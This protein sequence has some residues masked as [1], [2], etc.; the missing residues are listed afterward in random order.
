MLED[1]EPQNSQGDF[2]DAL[3]VGLSLFIEKFGDKPIQKRI[4]LVTDGGSPINYNSVDSITDALTER[5]AKLNVIGVGFS[6]AL[7]K[8]NMS[9]TQIE[10]EKQIRKIVQNV[11]GVLFPVANAIQMMSVLKSGQP[12]KTPVFKGCLE[13]SPLLK[14]PVHSF[15]K[16][17]KAGEPKKTRISLLSQDPDSNK[18]VKTQCEYFSFDNIDV[19]IPKTQRSK[20]YKYGNTIVSFSSQDEKVLKFSSA[21]GMKLIG[22][23]PMEKVP[24]YHFMGNVEIVA[25][26][27]HDKNAQSAISALAHAM[28]ETEHCAII[29]YSKGKNAPFIAALY[30]R[31]KQEMDS[32]YCV[33]L[34]FS[35]DIRDYPFQPLSD[36]EITEEQLQV[37][38]DVINALDLTK[39]TNDEGELEEPFKPKNIHNPSLQHLYQVLFHKALHPD[40]DIPPILPVIDESVSPDEELFRKNQQ[41]LT[42]FKNVFELIPTEEK[43]PQ[44]KFWSQELLDEDVNIDSYINASNKLPNT[45]VTSHTNKPNMEKIIKGNTSTVGSINPAN[46]FREMLARRDVDLVKKAISEVIVQTRRMIKESVYQSYYAKAIECIKELRYGCL[47]E[48]E[49]EDFNNFMFSIKLDMKGKTRN[50]FWEIVVNEKINLITVEENICSAITKEDAQNFLFGDLLPSVAN[51]LPEV[52]MPDAI[53]EPN[54]IDDLFDA[55]E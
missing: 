16:T 31:I 17:A 1:V 49:I 14:I 35:E 41:L 54:D 36:I 2:L 11:D 37:T 42:N 18:K 19:Q 12:R 38:E 10:N 46:D 22:F 7:D 44:K 5:Q 21:H 20:G 13:L 29:R 24:R 48:D 6:G 47:I 51:N 4:F 8:P 40:S 25:A 43:Q 30:P 50:D 39:V 33:K 15:K 45:T 32:L 3:V 53:E 28:A 26:V 9:D 23:T 27:Q 52:E 34:P 55:L